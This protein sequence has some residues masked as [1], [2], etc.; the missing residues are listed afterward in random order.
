MASADVLYMADGVN[1]N[2]LT[3]SERFYDNGKGYYWTGAG[4]QAYTGA[5]TLY[6]ATGSFAF[7]GT[8]E[9]R[10]NSKTFT[11]AAFAPLKADDQGCWYYTASNVLEYWNGTFGVFCHDVRTLPFGY[12]YDPD[13]ADELA[14]TQSLTI[15]MAFY[16]NAYN[17]P[18]NFSVAADWFLKG[19]DDADCIRTRG[20]GGYF[21]DYFLNTPASTYILFTGG[22]TYI[23]ERP[24]GIDS[25]QQELYT[26]LGL[27][28]QEGTFVRTHEGRIAYLGLAASDGVGHAITC[29]G[30][31]TDA[32]GRLTKLYIT[33]SDDRKYDLQTVYV[34]EDSF[35][36]VRLYTDAAC[37]M[38]WV[39]ASRQWI[40]DEIAYI[41]TPQKLEEMYAVYSAPETPL[42]WNGHGGEVWSSETP[43]GQLPD[44][45][46]GW[47]AEV[48]GARFA[49][50]AGENRI[51][52]LDDSA[53]SGQI[54]VSGAV[55]AAELRL[56]NST[57]DYVFSGKD[58]SISAPVS[59]TGHGSAGFI[60]VSLE[61]ESLSIAGYRMS[62]SEGAALTASTVNVQ[63][64]GVLQMDGAS[65]HLTS[66]LTLG[67]GGVLDIAASSSLGASSLVMQ[68][69]S[70]LR[71]SLSSPTADVPLLTYTGSVTLSG[72][73]SIQFADTRY[74]SA[75]RYALAS[76]TGADPAAWLNSLTCT[77][78]TLSVSNQV[79]YFTSGADAA[80][81]HTWT[82]SYGTLKEGSRIGKGVFCDGDR[83]EFRN[84]TA[85]TVTLEGEVKQS[86]VLVKTNQN[87]TLLADYRSKGHLAGSGQLIK[88]GTGQL[89][90][91]DGNTYTGGTQLR[92][93]TLIAM[94]KNAFG[95]GEIT[96]TGG[97]LDLGN[98]PIANDIILDASAVVRSGY[99][100]TGHLTV[101][102]GLLTGS[103]VN[104]AQ[105][106]DLR[107]GTVSGTLVGK[108]GVLINGDVRFETR[109]LYTG[110]TTLESGTLTLTPFSGVS[111]DIVVN[112]GT[113]A[114]A[115]S[116]LNPYV[117][118]ITL[119]YGQTLD[120]RSG[121]VTGEVT[122]GYNAV[123]RLSGGSLETAPTL[124]GGTLDLGGSG[125]CQLTGY[126]ATLSFGSQD[127][128]LSGA[129]TVRSNADLLVSAG[130]VMLTDA[131]N[132]GGDITLTGGTLTLLTPNGIGR[133]AVTVE[134]GTLDLGS[135]ALNNAV[136]VNGA[137]VVRGG[138]AYTGHL[139]VNADLLAGTYVNLAQ[140]ADLHGGTVNGMLVG[141]G[142]V[143]V[144]GDVRFESRQLYT[145]ATTIESG[146]L[147]L[148]PFSGV[149][150]D[151]VVNGGT[152]AVTTSSLN[153]YLK[154][155][156]LNYGQTL[157]IR[158]GKVTGEVTAGYNA[159]IRLSGGTLETAPTLAGGTLDLGGSGSCQLSG[160]GAT[161]SF[162][163][164][165]VKLSSSGTVLADAPLHLSS[166][167]VMLQSLKNVSGNL[168]LDGG[169]LT[170]ASASPVEND[171]VVSKGCKA[172]VNNGAVHHGQ[173]I[174][175]GSLIPGSYIRLTESTQRLELNGKGDLQ[176]VVSGIGSV[177]VNAV[178]N[179]AAASLNV[180][181]IMLNRG[182]ELGLPYGTGLFSG[183]E[184]VFNGGRLNCGNGT[185]TTYYGGTLN[186]AAPSTLTG[187]L[188]LCGGSVVFA[189]E[190]SLKVS[191]T[192]TLSQ[193]TSMSFSGNWEAGQQYELLTFGSVQKPYNTDLDSFFGLAEGM[194][195]DYVG[196]SL[197]LTTSAAR[198]RSM[199]E[200][201]VA[202]S[203]FEE[204]EVPEVQPVALAE[205]QTEPQTALAPEPMVAAAVTEEAP[206][207][208][209]SLAAEPLA[210][211]P[212]PPPSPLAA[213]TDALAQTDWGIAA[214]NRL[215]AGAVNGQ[216]DSG[217]AY[218]GGQGAL[219][220]SA[221]GA[222]RR[223]GHR[224][225]HHG[226][227]HNLCG[228]AF[229]LEHRMGQGGALGL[230]LGRT[231]N[232]MAAQGLS[233]V[234]Q[235]N[236]HLAL[237]GQQALPHGFAAEGSLS[238]TDSDT[239]A[240]FFGA[241]RT[242]A[243]RSFSASAGATHL[244][245]L[246]EKTALRRYVTLDYERVGSGS[247]DEL[248][249]GRAE[250]CR[251]AVG[252]A[253]RH[254]LT[255][256]T[257]LSAELSCFGDLLRHNP[258]AEAAGYRAEGAAPGRLGLH[259]TLGAA[260]RISETWSADAAYTLE[261]A[262]RGTTQGFRIGVRRSF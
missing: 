10:L 92:A 232:R 230:A 193:K 188:M 91:C 76:F 34:K 143:T 97:T 194:H 168:V 256:R 119:N 94:G 195:L 225:E 96:V 7:M 128:K 84:T 151:I 231:Q 16:D 170:L 192:L 15:G 117:K 83:L 179:A 255:P 79:L 153:P 114:V 57:R 212:A 99:A 175:D 157:D 258:T 202:L 138:Y 3:A 149:S 142:G 12:T 17:A 197:V 116:P 223:H 127:V 253:V 159:T 32:A 101:N 250:Q 6:N 211:V 25:F 110:A 228:A 29:Y 130:T 107:G 4:S 161:L 36:D 33:N 53:A 259:L 38:P 218:D 54:S 145:G 65:A 102:A 73:V 19:T 182:G 63:S 56:A 78:G 249:T 100:Y 75:T 251:A 206:V 70:S 140:T 257:S 35:H 69:G 164:Q 205:T 244:L 184:F 39:Y 213:V 144:N 11:T 248:R 181:T 28:S 166:G 133:G 87:L 135:R 80:V 234:R 254:E 2:D 64:G 126:G 74:D 41:N 49:S 9:K 216:R 176:A 55:S 46:A 204:E 241:K 62:F 95:S 82:S 156:T 177:H 58:A 173:I 8:L 207:A 86:E 13:Y 200:P 104:L 40:V 217:L 183:R 45:S 132:Y 210:S 5:R 219:W 88:E 240:D 31:E 167:H 43:K 246:G 60:G 239:R 26:A 109:Q 220:V 189:A 108:G 237:Y 245:T 160:Y 139:T 146:T 221:L 111:G 21:A 136:T 227:D 134:G 59:I 98:L 174:V 122:A 125:S 90:L 112:G 137:A 148:T 152:L 238:Y 68:D 196:N 162:G 20:Q 262:E 121:S 158:S 243:Q 67:R 163:S 229:G 247:A 124:A 52:C 198:L 147:T 224:G 199:A 48:E 235:E 141:K 131:K 169:N 23:N 72:A 214:A 30:F 236:A 120:I 242:W 105:T 233:H 222:Q 50:F 77:G 150:G 103:Y 37:S 129:G 208:E 209:M 81:T 89:L 71:F 187:N 44:A 113:L 178:V 51:L 61:T 47:V 27:E 24:K 191:G 180:S 215:F 155:I 171:I 154:G 118:G 22:S 93:G 201:L 203:A 85:A 226:A 252:A 42:Y 106:A 66:A 14:G 186:V 1:K 18:G 261:A 123:I 185:L 115:T 172:V 190:A 165:S 260:V